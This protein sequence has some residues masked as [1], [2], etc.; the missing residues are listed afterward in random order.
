[1]TV[2]PIQIRFAD[3][4]VLGH[5]NNV[6][7]QH[8]F[9]LGKAQYY[10]QVIGVPD[11][12]R[13]GLGLI[14]ASTAIS[15]FAQTRPTEEIEV[16]TSVPKIGNKSMTFVQRIVNGTTGE[17][18]AESTSVLVAFDFA[19]QDSV[20]VPEEWRRRIAEHEKQA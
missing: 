11:D 3:V 18:K 16:Q 4:D 1:M 17:V 12:W 2:T 6:N 13:G 9:D 10:K 15:Y 20:P 7:L 5:V 14:T 19:A 8:Y